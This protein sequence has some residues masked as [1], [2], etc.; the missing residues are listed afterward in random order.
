MYASVCVLGVSRQRHYDATLGDATRRGVCVA[1]MLAGRLFLP[2]NMP[3]LGCLALAA[4]AMSSEIMP[5][6]ASEGTLPTH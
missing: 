1:L 2:L 4:L 5:L 3:E 6:L